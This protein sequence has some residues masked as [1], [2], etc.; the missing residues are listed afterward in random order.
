MTRRRKT[1]FPTVYLTI[2][3]PKW[4]NWIQL[5]PKCSR[6][7]SWEPHTWHVGFTWA[8]LQA[9]L[10]N[11]NVYAPQS[12][13][14][15]VGILLRSLLDRGSIFSSWCTFPGRYPFKFRY[16]NLTLYFLNG[17]ALFYYINHN[18]IENKHE[19]VNVF[20]G[21]LGIRMGQW[22]YRRS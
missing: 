2:Y 20:N 21:V 3:L 10:F 15:F 17:K 22:C 19:Q 4:K 9:A 1:K 5:S 12:N 6:V 18:L 13:F 16:L 8:L 7:S 14:S 11:C